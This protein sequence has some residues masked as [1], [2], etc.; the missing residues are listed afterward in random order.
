MAGSLAFDISTALTG[1]WDVSS[2]TIAA[3]DYSG[4]WKLSL[5]CGLVGPIPLVLLGLIPKDKADQ[6]HLQQDT[7]RHFW[8]GVLFIVV[9]IATLIITFTESIY[10]VYFNEQDELDSKQR[11]LKRIMVGH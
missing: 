9:M 11:R 6:K 7:K 5:L 4:V 3:G 2:E 1:I 10:E 8:K